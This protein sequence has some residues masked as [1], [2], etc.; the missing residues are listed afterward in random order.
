MTSDP[1][2]STGPFPSR[3]TSVGYQAVLSTREIRMGHTKVAEVLG[4]GCSLNPLRV[5]V[6]GLRKVQLLGPIAPAHHP[7]VIITMKGTGEQ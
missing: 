2:W 1:A 3:A 5:G 4:Q 6:G 7:Y